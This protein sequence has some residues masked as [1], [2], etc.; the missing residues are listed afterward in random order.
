MRQ[1]RRWTVDDEPHLII[2]TL[3]V[4]YDAA[5]RVASHRHSVPQLLYAR[6]GA[7]RA[8][9]AGTLWLVPPRRALWIPA[10]TEHGLVALGSVDL[11][12]LYCG[13]SNLEDWVEVRSLTVCGLL[14]EALLRACDLGGLDARRPDQRRLADL[15]GDELRDADRIPELLTMPR[16]PRARRLADLMLERMGDGASLDPLLTEAGLSRR[17]AERLFYAQ[18]GLSPARWRQQACLAAS[19]ERLA[20]G[21]RVTEVA[22]AAGY[23]SPSA[24]SAAFKRV[25]GIAPRDVRI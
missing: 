18:T 16:D 8:E 21:A 14:H 11:R 17:T 22:L 13:L 7:L 5:G 12:T 20:A 23:A 6:A 25:L 10:G 19:F 2:R 9:V 4:T 15:I 3:S 1:R 24:F